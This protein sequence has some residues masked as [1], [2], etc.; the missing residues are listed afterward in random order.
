MRRVRMPRHFEG[1]SD[2]DLQQRALS[3]AADREAAIIEALFRTRDAL[4][5]SQEA[6]NRLTI[7]IRR[8]TRWLVWLTLAILILTALVAWPALLLLWRSA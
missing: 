5:T 4:A 7:S 1:M 3:V 8:L 6:T 2:A